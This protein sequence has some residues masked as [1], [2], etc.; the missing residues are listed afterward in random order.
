[1]GN[2]HTRIT[3]L[4]DQMEELIR[5]RDTRN[6]AEQKSMMAAAACIESLRKNIDPPQALCARLRGESLCMNRF[7]PAIAAHMD[8]IADAFETAS[9]EGGNTP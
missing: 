3:A 5:R 6:P 1:M 7:S 8:L 9:H 4:A 2:I